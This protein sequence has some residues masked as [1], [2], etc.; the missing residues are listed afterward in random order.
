MDDDNIKNL[1][2]KFKEPPDAKAFL[3]LTSSPGEC[4][5]GQY[6]V[7]SR[8]PEVEC[9]KCK[10]KMDPMVV[11]REMAYK[12]TQWHRTRAFYQEEMKRLEERSR[13]KCQ[14]CGKLT[15]ISR[16]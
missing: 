7:D 11:L 15:R 13:T 14:H 4:R 10:Q 2:V 3:T 9:S 12:E 16:A 8:K 6:E 1:P 5:H